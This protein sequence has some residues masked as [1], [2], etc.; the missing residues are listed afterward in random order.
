MGKYYQR[1]LFDKMRWFHKSFYLAGLFSQIFEVRAEKGCTL[2]DATREMQMEGHVLSE[3]NVVFN[4]LRRLKYYTE[5][6]K[7]L[8]QIDPSLVFYFE[9]PETDE[10]W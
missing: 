8:S 7:I 5:G 4:S 3:G 9:L 1:R 2:L 6:Q 10:E